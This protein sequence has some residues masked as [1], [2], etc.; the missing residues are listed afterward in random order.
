MCGIAGFSVHPESAKALPMKEI[1]KELLLG[2]EHRGHDATGMAWFGPKGG[3]VVDKAAKNATVFTNVIKM[4]NDTSTA[5]LHTRLATTGSP[6]RNN[7]N[8]PIVAPGTKGSR[9]IGTH[10]G[11]VTNY[12]TLTRNHDLPRNAEVDSEVIFSWLAK[13][14]DDMDKL[15]ANIDGNYAIAYIREDDPNTIHL[16]RGHSSPLVLMHTVFGVFYASEE[17]TLRQ[18][19]QYV[20]GPQVGFT[21]VAEGRAFT[22]HEGDIGN[23]RSFD[24]LEAWGSYYGNQVHG[25]SSRTVYLPWEDDK[26]TSYTSWRSNHTAVG[27]EGKELTTTTR[28]LDAWT[29]T[30]RG[31]RVYVNQT[32]RDR[33]KLANLGK[34]KGAVSPGAYGQWVRVSKKG[35]TVEFQPWKSLPEGMSVE[36]AVLEELLYLTWDVP[37]EDMD[38]SVAY[39]IKSLSVQL[40]RKV[41]ANEWSRRQKNGVIFNNG[42]YLTDKDQV[43][44]KDGQ[45]IKLKDLPNY[46]KLPDAAG[47]PTW[48]FVQAKSLSNY[49]LFVS[50]YQA[51]TDHMNPRSLAP[52]A[53][54]VA[55]YCL[56]G[57]RIWGL[58]E[59]GQWGDTGI[60]VSELDEEELELLGISW[61]PMPPEEDDEDKEPT[62]PLAEVLPLV[63]RKVS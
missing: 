12:G 8:H 48:Y 59:H 41:H 38:D 25:S 3:A 57:E 13:Y 42:Q 39:E 61:T 20:G 35:D 50:T 31:V 22:L 15:G 4:G 40:D 6:S 7:N 16:A 43:A 47:K 51:D 5:I 19:Q 14:G 28:V 34:N 56:I 29:D 11:W 18:I 53:A 33:A 37:G 17:Y 49:T 21:E 52:P 54:G 55:D 62:L 45:V 26:Y 44:D 2:I 27:N 23:I 10:N 9:V 58:N 46:I 36:E 1:A 32:A 63:G 60:G 24:M 30:K